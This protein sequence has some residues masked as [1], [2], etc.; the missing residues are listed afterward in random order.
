MDRKESTPQREIRRAYE[1]RHK[2][3]RKAKNMVWGTSV[4]RKKAEEMNEFLK[5]YGFTKIQLIEAG[6]GTLIERVSEGKK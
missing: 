4:P 6:Y 5:K 2:E 1:E 3:E